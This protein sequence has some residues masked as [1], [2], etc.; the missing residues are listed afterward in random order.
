MNTATITATQQ[1]SLNFDDFAIKQQSVNFD[2]FAS[3]ISDN[4]LEV[5]DDTKLELERIMFGE[6]AQELPL[7]ISLIGF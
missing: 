3:S 2:N 4:S 5:L 6:F 1:Q 7:D